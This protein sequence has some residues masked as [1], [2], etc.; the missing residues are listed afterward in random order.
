MA[1]LT[2]NDI[3]LPPVNIALQSSCRIPDDLTAVEEGSTACNWRGVAMQDPVFLKN[4][5]QLK[6]I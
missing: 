6:E 1:L 5:I 2:T 4:F 3:Y